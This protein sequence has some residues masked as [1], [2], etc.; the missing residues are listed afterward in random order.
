VPNYTEAASDSPTHGTHG[1]HACTDDDHN[2]VPVR[3]QRWL[4]RFVATAM[5]ERLV[6]REEAFLLQNSS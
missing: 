4:Q 3:L 6:W 5:G 1:T 2:P